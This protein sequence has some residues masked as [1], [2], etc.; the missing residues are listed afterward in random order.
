[1]DHQYNIAMKNIASGPRI[2]SRLLTI[3]R[4]P[5]ASRPRIAVKNIFF[6]PLFLLACVSSLFAQRSIEV[7][8]AED[9]KGNYN[10]SCTNRAWCNYVLEINFTKLSNVVADHPLPFRVMVTPG[11]NKLFKLTKQ[12]PDD[13]A[14]FN[15]KAAFFKGCIDPQVD[16]G[17]TYLFP[18]GAG[19]TAQ[20]YEMGTMPRSPGDPESKNSYAIRLKMKPGDTIY[21][22]RRGIVDEIDVSSNLNDSGVANSGSGNYIEIVHA[23]C[24]FG[25]Y[26]IIKRNGAFVHPGQ[27][28]GA[29]QPIG[30]VGGDKYGRGSEIR[31][32]VYYNQSGDQTTYR[33]YT[34]LKFWTKRNGKGMLKHGGTYTG[35]FPKNLL[36]QETPHHSPKPK[37]H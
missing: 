12:H 28:V 17:F 23:D 18:A 14:E 34:P 21:A 13:A 7:S 2:A 26:G 19:R 32:W 11:N 29:G 36:T 27:T 22:A 10:F 3:Y 33:L 6:F 24:S 4:L 20:A 1:L 37:T 16:T 8:Y 35:E 9:T 5:F 25:R 31:I 30:L 15:Y